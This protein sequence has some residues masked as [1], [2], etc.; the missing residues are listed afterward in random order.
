LVG[1][2]QQVPASAVHHKDYALQAWLCPLR[3]AISRTPAAQRSMRVRTLRRVCGMPMQCR[4]CRAISVQFGG[5][6]TLLLL[7]RGRLLRC[8]AARATGGPS[9]GVLMLHEV[10]QLALLGMKVL[11]VCLL[12][13][14]LM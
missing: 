3:A 14:M 11:A 9:A 1:H 8:S 7:T 12:A 6:W 5:C 10:V 2:R 4:T 13:H